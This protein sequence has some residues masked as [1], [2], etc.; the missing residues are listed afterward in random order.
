MMSRGILDQRG[1]VLGEKAGEKKQVYI[2]YVDLKKPYDMN[3]REV[4]SK[5]LRIKDV[6]S[7]LLNSIKSMYVNSL[8][9][10]KIKRW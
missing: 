2:D 1:V 9:N 7:K 10:C 5:V 3:Y 4:R 6:G 8:A